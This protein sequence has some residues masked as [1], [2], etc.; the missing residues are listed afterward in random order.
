MKINDWWDET[1]QPLAA[2]MP[3]GITRITG[4]YYGIRL[5]SRMTPIAPDVRF[6]AGRDTPSAITGVKLRNGEI[7]TFLGLHPR[8]PRVGQSALPRDA[9]GGTSH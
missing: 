7:A 1:L 5:F 4:S 8:P 2:D 3:F 6:L 9:G